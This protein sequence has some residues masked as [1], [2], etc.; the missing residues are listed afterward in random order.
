[1]RILNLLF[2][3]CGVGV[4]LLTI[5]DGVMLAIRGKL[6]RS[7]WPTCLGLLIVVII[8]SVIVAII[9]IVAIAEGM[10]EAYS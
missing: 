10:S 2:L 7:D 1:M 4:L 3:G 9:F 5:V 8:V 6:K